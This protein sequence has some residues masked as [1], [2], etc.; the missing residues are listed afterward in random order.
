MW[1]VIG[2][3]KSYSRPLQ[4]FANFAVL[5]FAFLQTEKQSFNRKGRKEKRAEFA[6]ET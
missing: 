2:I 4:P 3:F 5:D 6:K 1:T